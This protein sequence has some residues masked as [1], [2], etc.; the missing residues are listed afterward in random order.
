MVTESLFKDR[1]LLLWGY[2]SIYE[3]ITRGLYN[4]AQTV[5]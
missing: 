5:T 1:Y 4:G 3:G 2:L